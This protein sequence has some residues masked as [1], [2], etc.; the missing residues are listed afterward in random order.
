MGCKTVTRLRSS[1]KGK[2][3]VACD[4]CLQLNNPNSSERDLRGLMGLTGE[5]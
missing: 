5:P 1:A 4:E 3:V 2:M